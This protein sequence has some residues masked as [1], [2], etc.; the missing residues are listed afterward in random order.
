MKK[1]LFF[2]GMLLLGLSVNALTVNPIV[3]NVGDVATIGAPSTFAYASIKFPKSNFI[4]KRGGIVNYSN[5]SGVRVE[6]VSIENINGTRIVVI[7]RADGRKFFNVLPTA[8][9]E[10]EASVYKKEL[11]L[12]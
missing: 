2:A 12:N 9:V 11:V 8:K 5:L 10:L 7:K 6:V 3:V 1:K 4:I